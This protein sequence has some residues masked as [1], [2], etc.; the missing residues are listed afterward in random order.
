MPSAE[1][2]PDF[3]PDV[4][5]ELAAVVDEVGL[6]PGAPTTVWRFTGKVLRGNPNALSFYR[7][8]MTDRPLSPSFE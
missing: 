8:R 1:A 3:N 4:E 7:A 5:M 2:T 6:L